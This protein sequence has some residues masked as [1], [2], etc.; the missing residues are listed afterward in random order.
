MGMR[1]CVNYYRTTFGI[2]DALNNSGSGWGWG[3]FY[4][5]KLCGFKKK[6]IS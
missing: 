2:D 3:E 6:K 1:D 5:V 4:T